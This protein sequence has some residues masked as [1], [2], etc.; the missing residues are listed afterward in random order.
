MEQLRVGQ[1]DMATG[2][3]M[4]GAQLALIF[5]KRKNGFREGWV[6]MAQNPMVELA[7]ANIGNEAMR[8]MFVIVGNLDYENWININQ[9]Q[10]AA[11]L[12]MDRKNFGRGLKKLISEGVILEGPKVGRNGTYRLN[13]SYGWKGSAKGHH[14]ALQDR[15]KARGLSVVE[16]GPPAAADTLTRD[17][18]DQG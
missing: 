8:V 10:L 18:F 12:E 2:E 5:P 1:V 3:I 9:A 14:E 13:P 4:E 11:T 17:M 15:M 16:G 6:A 7:K